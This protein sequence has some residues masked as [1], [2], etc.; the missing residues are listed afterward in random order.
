ME[1][2]VSPHKALLRQNEALRE[3][4]VNLNA[5]SMLIN[6]SLD[7]DNVLRQVVDS[8]RALT[9]ARYGILIAVGQTGELDVLFTSGIS[10]E[11]HD[12]LQRMPGR[13]ELFGYFRQ[14]PNSL[15][16]TDFPSYAVETGLPAFDLLP[17]GAFLSAPMRHGG[18]NIGYVHLARDRGEGEFT[19]EDEET[20]VMF[21]SQA[22]LV[23][24]NARR[25]RDE[26]RARADLEALADT[27]PV[28]VLVFDATTGML[29]T[30]NGEARRIGG[31]RSL[32][33]DRALHV[34]SNLSVRRPNGTEISLSAVALALVMSGGQKLRAEEM[35]VVPAEGPPVA[36]L[37]D[38]TP[39]RSDN[40]DAVSIVVTM[41]DMKL[42]QE[43]E[44]SRTDFLAM[45]SHELRTPL[46]AI[47]GSASTVLDDV[48]P[49][50]PAE[51]RQFFR[52]VREQADRMRSLVNDLLDVAQIQA[53][54]LSVAPMSSDVA[55]LVDQ[56][57]SI[58][59]GGG[60]RNNL[61]F[62]IP[63]GLPPVWAD[64]IRIVQVLGNLLNNAAQNSPDGSRI[65]V[66]VRSEH[67]QVLI[68]VADEGRGIPEERLPQLFQ[69]YSRTEHDE[70]GA[71]TSDHGL[72]LAICKGIV[73][74]HGGRIWAESD[75]AGLGS[76]FSFTLP[77]AEVA[78][79]ILSNAL[80]SNTRPVALLDPARVL[81]VDDDPQ[82][83]RHIRDVLTRS[84]F[85]P[86][87]TDDP[88]Q[89][90]QM[91]AAHGPNLVLMDLL[92]PGAGGIELMGQILEDYDVPVMFVSAYGQEDVVARAFDM[93]AVDYVVKPFLPT[94][95]VARIRSVLR[96]SARPET[97][98]PYVH[99]D[100][101][102]DYR[103]RLATLAG[104]PL[105][106][107]PTEYQLLAE[108]ASHGGRLVTHAQL[109]HRVWGSASTDDLRPV[110][111]VIR[112]L[113]RKLGQVPD[114]PP[115]IFTQP[116]V[117]YRMPDPEPPSS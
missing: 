91:M 93:G 45:V 73:E 47:R 58:F 50:D 7:F 96:R 109:L 97:Q 29:R 90:Q 86:I 65:T 44:R 102:V 30:A 10:E 41:Q 61:V 99:G 77:V 114:G 107:T 2:T 20:L 92:L 74:T 103:R 4:L 17:V 88:S 100:L 16:L 66:R 113:R 57:R 49:L 39:L 69:K 38:A 105:P 3:R 28:G 80:G 117:G 55:D 31:T 62:D 5:A 115:Y 75:R 34:L 111:T 83:L 101:V 95:L 48:S 87:L 12:R 54:A 24:G 13:W 68:S 32:S 35:A 110:R 116:R 19:A 56:A 9:E 14:M 89:V 21:A 104:E 108:L 72:G 70:G 15:R 85:E 43:M 106:L 46:A 11:D 37:V 71:G 23:I 112:K 27:S 40:G 94:E 33:T 67:C 25:Y 63:P 64:P 76:R 79:A 81:V 6:E 59:L 18:Q 22:A 60:G 36:V 82:A 78:D 51:V 98:K 1:C 52:I 26:Q 8:A 42:F 53:G 84:G